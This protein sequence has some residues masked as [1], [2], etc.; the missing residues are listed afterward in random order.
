MPPSSDEVVNHLAE[1]ALQVAIDEDM[2]ET[3]LHDR[4]IY[5]GVMPR[6]RVGL[7]C[8]PAEVR[9]HPEVPS[10]HRRSG[11]DSRQYNMLIIQCLLA[12]RYK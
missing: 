5:D 12:I 10:P 4:R 9:F 6:S 7:D 1:T 2:I 8:L 11:D 3:P